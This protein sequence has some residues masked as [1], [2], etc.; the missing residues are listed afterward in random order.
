MRVESG[1]GKSA[2]RVESRRRIG[3]T[4]S[5]PVLIL[6]IGL[7]FVARAQ[8]SLAVS[9]QD[10]AVDS[11]NEIIVQGIRA[12]L[13]SA[14]ETKRS[15]DTVV[16]AIN[17][18]DVGH[19]PDIN[20]AES[21]QRIS[22]V[23]IT[24]NRGEGQT[25]N[26]RGMPAIFTQTTLN[27]RSV[28]NALV[29]ADASA[30]RAFDFSILA[31]EFIRT[32]EVY[33]APTADLEEGGL[34]GTVNIRTPHALDIGKRIIAGSIEGEYSDSSAKFAPRASLL[35][36]DS[37]ADHRLG[38][39]IGLSYSRRRPETQSVGSSYNY[40][41]EGA[42]LGS[43]TVPADLNSDGVIT[44][45][46]GVRIPGNLNYA[47]YQEDRK[48]LSAIGSIEYLVTDN[49]K[50]YAD[51]LYSRLDIFAHRSENNWFLQNSR[52]LIGST[53]LPSPY[54]GIPTVEDIEL[55]QLDL[56]A[57][58]RVEDSTGHVSNIV[59]GG[60][61]E[62]DRLQVEL[63]GSRSSSRQKFSNVALATTFVGHGYFQT[64]VGAD[65]PGA[66]FVGSDAA[67]YLDPASY[68]VASVNGVFRNI[69]T[70]RQYDGH[71]GVIRTFGDT[72]L[73]R[74][75]IGARY[76]H[77][78]RFQNNSR[79]T[80]LPAAISSLYGG[81]PA[82]SLPGSFSAAPLMHFVKA[83][84]GPALGSYDGSPRFPG[85]LLVSDPHAFILKQSTAALIAAGSYTND[86]SGI[87]DVTEETIAGYVRADFAFDRLS[88]NIGARVVQTSQQ[89]IGVS[90]DLSAI[91]LDL[92][93]GAV[94]RV[95]A[96]VP[97][98]VDRRYTEFLPSL[99]L[100]YKA[101]DTLQFRMSLSR[102]LARPNLT[103]IAPTTSANGQN[104]TISQQNPYLDPYLAN[105]VDVTAEWYFA[106]GALLGVSGFYKDL[107]SLVQNVSKVQSLPVQVIGSDGSLSSRD[108]TFTVN[109]LVNTGG[110]KLKGFEFLYQQGL[111]FLPDPLDGLGITANYTFID[112]SDPY[113]LTAA[114][115]HNFN[116]TGYY[117]KGPVGV[118]LSYAWRGGYVST[119]PQ[120][121]NMGIRTDSFG[122]LD[123][124]ASLQ[125]TDNVSLTLEAVNLLGA[126]QV[127]HYLT[128]LPNSY[129][130]SGRRLLFGARASF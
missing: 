118:R 91:T 33:K 38:V 100:R 19:Y 92:R 13:D 74:I 43:S 120:L 46:L 26:I 39:T 51:G 80:I 90:P 125:V 21:L 89:S 112:N 10:N 65:V 12:S 129:S 49:L 16:D 87:T 79:L 93:A 28:A 81:L 71:I 34:S 60:I 68:R 66:G 29:N 101:S 15:A 119:A 57:N 83:G 77:R 8:A 126:A 102:T 86:P 116:L 20:I 2:K 124:S 6:A 123:G 42:A 97:I 30:T 115:R 55:S 40:Q 32:L 67:A 41:R 72:G 113:K 54:D 31:P 94:T 75:A 62:R 35:F 78:S 84:H 48:R 128:N 82:G 23:Q 107:K 76:A 99:N 37:F 64:D 117:E 111:T 110:V 18:E 56:R 5:L 36:A 109:R 59:L 69:G 70:D 14:L 44:P 52:G 96:A 22:G 88:G 4:V 127:A 11:G 50:L 63:S 1:V 130:Y 114:S 85:T 61:W 58:G 104:L 108:L 73:T 27:G 122:T 45:T 103:D 7:P 106:R 24:R 3:L 53:I 9:S 98:S 95:P 47:L 105:N 17:A 121:P 25:V